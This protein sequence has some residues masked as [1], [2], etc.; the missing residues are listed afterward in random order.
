MMQWRA[1]NSVVVS[2]TSI[3]TAVMCVVGSAALVS[4]QPASLRIHYFALGDSVAAGHGLQDDGSP[5]RRSTRSYPH[6]VREQLAVRYPGAVI[7]FRLLACSG[8]TTDTAGDVTDV[9]KS[10]RS[11]VDSVVE[12]ASGVTEPV[13]VSATIGAN[14]LGWSNHRRLIRLLYGQRRGVFERNV[15]SITADLQD[16]LSASLRLLTTLPNVYVV[17]TDYPNPMNSDSVFFVGPGSECAVVDCY[18]RSEFAI[19]SLNY[20]ITQA[21]IGAGRPPNLRVA[22]VHEAFHGHEGPRPDCGGNHPLARYSWIQRK[23]DAT[24]NGRPDLPRRLGPNGEWFGDCIHPNDDGARAYARAV[25]RS[26]ERVAPTL[27]ELTNEAPIASFSLSLGDRVVPNTAELHAVADSITGE[28]RVTFTDTSTDA[29]GVGDVVHREWR[30]NTETM[31]ISTGTSEFTWG[32]TPGEPYVVTLLIRDSAQQLSTAT[33]TITVTSAPHVPLLFYDR[34]EAFTSFGQPVIDS[35]GN[36]LAVRSIFGTTCGFG[37][38]EM[39]LDSISPAGSLNWETPAVAGGDSIA[40]KALFLGP[41]DRAHVLGRTDISAFEPNGQQAAGWPVQ[42]AP[43]FNW[44][45]TGIALDHASGTVFS[46]LGVFGQ[47][48]NSCHKVVTA[49]A[50]DGT[51]VWERPYPNDGTAFGIVPG[52]NGRLYTMTQVVSF[53]FSVTLVGLDPLSG[54][55]T[56]RVPTVA[57]FGTLVGGAGGV[58]TSYGDSVTAYDSNCQPR[59]LYRSPFGNVQ[60]HAYVNGIVVGFEYGTGVAGRLIGIRSDGTKWE[61]TR[62]TSPTANPLFVSAS[63]GPMIYLFGRD[64]AA[65]NAAKLFEVDA[66]SGAIVRSIDTENLCGA[67]DCGVAA[68]ANGTLYIND[69]RSTRIYRIR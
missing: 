30:V 34:G 47:C 33:A 14:D 43:V 69:L 67:G 49:T 61:N 27:Q 40:A 31:P 62:I 65:D 12:F 32:F 38:C 26:I 63:R 53:P 42:L 18:D 44:T 37:F 8:A 48:F 6:L 24:L 59:L 66:S 22:G 52:P 11:Q 58:F 50:R 20:A 51:V 28:A 64:T 36:V 5:C 3:A 7:D 1:G 35:Q 57:A 55:E 23:S 54:A 19:H 15:L 4:A 25:M 60:S 46:S 21:A 2:L 13:I 45:F 10:F 17:I 29:D 41:N 9:Y 68:A 39:R 16:E 56:C